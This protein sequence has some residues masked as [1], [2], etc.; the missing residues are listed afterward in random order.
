MINPGDHVEQRGFTRTGFPNDCYKLALDQVQ[1]EPLRTV[2]SPAVFSVLLDHL[3]EPNGFRMG[4]N[5]HTRGVHTFACLPGVDPLETISP[6]WM[7]R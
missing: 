2:T 1:V 4:S 3:G 5:W 7:I 6:S